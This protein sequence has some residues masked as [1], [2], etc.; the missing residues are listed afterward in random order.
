MC[1]NCAKRTLTRHVKTLRSQNRNAKIKMLCLTDHDDHVHLKLT[2]VNGFTS[3]W[4]TVPFVN[5]D[6]LL[7]LLRMPR[8]IPASR[9]ES[10]PAV[11]VH[12]EQ[13]KACR[14]LSKNLLDTLLLDHN[15]SAFGRLTTNTNDQCPVCFE[16]D[17]SDAFCKTTLPC[18]HIMCHSCCKKWLNQSTECPVCRATITDES[19]NIQGTGDSNLELCKES[20]ENT[21][22]SNDM[23]WLIYSPQYFKRNGASI[24]KH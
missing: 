6:G 1:I 10:G 15:Q 14:G 21:I 13:D 17:D 5:K 2:F 11:H 18:G 7:T 9:W 16:T 23:V 8:V 20:K 19:L 12:E 4:F 22:H 24:N 3:E